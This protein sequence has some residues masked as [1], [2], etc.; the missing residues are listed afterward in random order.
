MN[1]AFATTDY[2]GQEQQVSWDGISLTDGE[3]FNTFMKNDV[4]SRLYDQEENDGFES[5]LRSLASTGFAKEESLNRILSAE[6]LEERDWAV[7]EALSEAWLNKEYNVIWPWNM[8][9]DK[10]NPKASLPGADLIGFIQINNETRFAFGEVKSSSE[11]KYPPQVMSSRLGHMGHQI[12]NLAT[13][14]S[15]IFQ[16]LKWL[17]PRCKGTQHEL[18]YNSSIILYLKSGNKAVSLFGVLVRD[19]EANELDLKA[20][21]QALGTTLQSPTVCQLIALY[22][23]CTIKEL[24]TRVKGGETS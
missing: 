2:T 1:L 23:P 14:L 8:E 3:E 24:P 13:N 7:G 22:L 17:S 11:E 18:L 4:A 5:H 15:L 9:R 20:C 6:I 19:T 12:N 21:G 10:R 16:L